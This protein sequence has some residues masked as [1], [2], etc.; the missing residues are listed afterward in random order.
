MVHVS[1]NHTHL[2]STPMPVVFYLGGRD[3]TLAW[4]NRLY[5]GL[6]W[7]VR[8]FQLQWEDPLLVLVPNS[9]HRQMFG[10]TQENPLDMAGS[11]FGLEVVPGGAT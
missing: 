7:P 6:C 3:L 8:Q 4:E 1:F 10:H 5:L 9:R 11:I 2:Y